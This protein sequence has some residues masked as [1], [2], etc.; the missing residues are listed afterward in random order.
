MAPHLPS[1]AASLRATATRVSCRWKPYRP[2]GGGKEEAS[3]HRFR[4]RR[5]SLTLVPQI[6]VEY[7]ATSR[8][9]DVR[10]LVD[11]VHEAA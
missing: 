5:C 8:R 4:A 7:R 2:E 1:I 3:T 6:T 11:A 9:A 10:A